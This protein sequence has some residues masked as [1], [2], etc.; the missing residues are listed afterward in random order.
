MHMSSVV[1]DLWSDC[2]CENVACGRCI[3]LHD[4]NLGIQMNSVKQ[5]VTSNSVGSGYV[6][7]CWTSAFDDHLNHCFAVLKNVQHLTKMRR[8]RVRR[9]MI[10]ITQ[11]KI[12]VLGWNFGLVLGVLVCRGVTRRVSSYLIFGVVELV[13]VKNGT[14]AKPIPKIKRGNSVHA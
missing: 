13:L 3:C 5:S 2:T 10:N 6:S 9:N 8:L 1:C 7:H 4:L 11:I 12:V 14:L